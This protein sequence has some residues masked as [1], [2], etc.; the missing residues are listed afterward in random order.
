M[1][2]RIFLIAFMIFMFLG[3]SKVW[4]T[5]EGTT[6]ITLSDDNVL[7]NE[8]TISTNTSETIYLTSTMNNGGSSEEAK[9]ANIKQS[10]EGWSDQAEVLY[11][12]EKGYDDDRQYYERYKY[13]GAIS[14]DISLTF[15]GEGTL[16]VNGTEKEGIESKRDITINSGEYKINSL[17]DGINA[18]TDLYR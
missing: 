3:I 13:D 4:A 8:S 16:T 7:V 9:K 1:R 17:D 5:D 15:E 6:T 12:I 14:S 18:C 2:K 10:V 11:H